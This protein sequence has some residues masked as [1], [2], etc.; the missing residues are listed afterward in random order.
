LDAGD[1]ETGHL[2]QKTLDDRRIGVVRVDHN[3][4]AITL[5]VAIHR[6]HPLVDILPATLAH[7]L[8]AGNGWQDAGRSQRM[9]RGAVVCR[10]RKSL[11][12]KPVQRRKA[13]VKLLGSWNP[14]S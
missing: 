14:S 5:A 6:L 8:A 1:T 2:R 4:Q 10:R 3:R 13:R 7:I 9:A 12:L 11:G